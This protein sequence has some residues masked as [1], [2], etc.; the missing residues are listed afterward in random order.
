VTPFGAW[1]YD[2]DEG[3]AAALLA[4]CPIGCVLVSHSPP[5]GVV[6]VSS[7]G[8]SLGSVAVRAAVV[9]RKPL[10]VVCGHIHACAGEQ[11]TLASSPV[12]NDGPN[13]VL[14]ELERHG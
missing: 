8:Q 11:A 5:K 10:L 2:F 4:D 7:R 12:V 14:W 3:E 9:R 13:G 1:S 6:D